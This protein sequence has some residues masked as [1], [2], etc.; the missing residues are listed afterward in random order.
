MA[1]KVVQFKAPS[2]EAKGNGTDSADARFLPDLYRE[3]A[4]NLKAYLHKKYGA[5]PPDPED[6]THEVF[7]RLAAIPPERLA[8]I[9]HPQ[10][11]MFRMA[12]NLLIS[13]KRREHVSAAHAAQIAAIDRDSAGFECSPDRV[14]LAKDQ[15]DAAEAIIRAMPANRRQCFLLHRFEGLSFAEIGRRLG[16]SAVGARGHVERAMRDIHAALPASSAGWKQD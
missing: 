2:G 14:L 1:D 16:M 9:E 3:R 10:A 8:T 7:T 11:F 5:G 6:I 15:L 12:E 13:A 4:R